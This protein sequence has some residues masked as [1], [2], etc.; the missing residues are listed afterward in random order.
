MQALRRSTAAL[1]LF[2]LAVA[3]C[4]GGG[5]VGGSGGGGGGGGSAGFTSLTTL[6]SPGTPADSRFGSSIALCDWDGDGRKD[7]FVGM[8]GAANGA[9]ANAGKVLLFLQAPNGTF[10]T[11]PTRTILPTNWGG[12]VAAD[13]ASF[14]ETIECGDFNGDG[15]SDLVI[16]APG[17]PVSL[18]PGA[19]RI[20]LL[21]NNVSHTGVGFGP[22]ADPNGAAANGGF[23]SALAVG[24]VNVDAFD[25]LAVGA[26]GTTIAAHPGAGRV[27][28]LTGSATLASFGALVGTTLVHTAPS[29]DANFG[30][31]LVIADF[32]GGGLGDI[33]VG[34]PGQLLNAGGEV[35]IYNASPNF[36]LLRSLSTTQPGVAVEFGSALAAADLDHDGDIDLL[37]GAPY[38][39][40]GVTL[41]AGYVVPFLNTNPATGTFATGTAVTARTLEGGS[42]FGAVILVPGDL[43]GDLRPECVIAAPAA[44]FGVT[45]G[46]GALTLFRSAGNG[47]FVTPAAADVYGAGS[48]TTDGAAGASLAAADLDND[49]IPDLVVGAP[50]PLDALSLLPGQVEILHAQ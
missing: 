8:P 13:G 18:T 50:G 35:R 10:P 28:C 43:T 26:P 47:T 24:R 9:L 34:I 38:G 14:G 19:G 45:A 12:G 36:T 20:Y 37:V 49:S 23:G 11:V 15:R 2:L 42:Q 6:T 22:Y 17:D 7:M 44:A 16:G 30:A 40:V 3:G 25:D 1:S 41:E 31:A 48:P 39:D 27:A 33:A 21:A 4:G 5:S 29:D 32:D 46:A